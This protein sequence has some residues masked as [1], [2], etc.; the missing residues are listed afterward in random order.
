MLDGLSSRNVP[1]RIAAAEALTA[2]AIAGAPPPPYLPSFLA[3]CLSSDA[4][5]EGGGGELRTLY[6][7]ISL[8]LSLAQAQNATVQRAIAQVIEHAYS[9]N[10]LGRGG[11]APPS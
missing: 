9:R 1:A 11:G 3:F 6:Q 8:V 2:I 5:T 7:W 4:S 10:R